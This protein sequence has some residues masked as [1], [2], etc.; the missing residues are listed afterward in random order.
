MS[1]PVLV[2][3]GITGDLSKRKLLPALYHLLSQGQLPEDTTILGISRRPLSSDELLEQ[4][5]LCVLEKD[6]VCD[7]EG[8]R[9]MQAALQSVQ[10]DP[11]APDDFARLQQVLDSLDEEGKRD[12]IIYMS[13][14]P[15]AYAPIVQRLGEHGLNDD[16]TR[17][18]IEKPFGYDLASAES[19]IGLLAEHYT[20]RQI[21]RIDHYLAK[22]TAQNLLTFRMHN[23]IF[24]HLWNNE[25]IAQVH[26]LASESLGVESRSDFYEKTGALRDLIQSHLMQLLAMVLMDIPGSMESHDIHLSKQ[27]FLEQLAAANPMQAVRAQYEGYTDEV[28][29]PASTIE[30][31][32]KVRLQ[33]G[34]RRWQGTEIILETGKALPAKNTSIT[35]TFKGTDGQANNRLLFQLQPD[36]GIRLDLVVKKPGYGNETE[37][38]AL[39]FTYESAFADEQHIDAYERVLMD[40]VRADQA[41][42]ASSQEVLATWRVLQPT[43]DAWT[44]NGEGL[45]R[46]KRGSVPNA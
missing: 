1:A 5:E 4:V 39:S 10:L 45:E 22:E 43:I 32:A 13:I 21:Y 26:I 31:Y 29:N 8:L 34:A 15:D 25:H 28:D 7:P 37:T 41:L 20:E 2:I 38:T 12:R 23:P 27:C 44:D 9:R 11:S 24:T 40:A 30:T 46:Y 42:F 36:E 18:L 14:P 6:N 16:R 3:F 35:L 33:H 17:L 19:L